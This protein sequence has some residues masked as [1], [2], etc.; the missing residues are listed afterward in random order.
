M[1]NDKNNQSQKDQI[2]FSNNK[3][4]SRREAAEFLGIS[5]GTLEV[6]SCTKRYPLKFI[7]VGRLVKYRE[8]DLLEFLDLMTQGHD[9]I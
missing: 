2:I 3:L 4:L 1:P 7:K 9:K 6:W 8:R 5:K